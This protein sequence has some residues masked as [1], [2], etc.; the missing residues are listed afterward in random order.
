MRTAVA[1]IRPSTASFTIGRKRSGTGFALQGRASEKLG[2]IPKL[3]LQSKP[4]G[5]ETVKIKTQV[6]AGGYP[7]VD[8]Q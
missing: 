4:K 8:H 1:G 3:F 5:G 6:K 2:A 7:Y